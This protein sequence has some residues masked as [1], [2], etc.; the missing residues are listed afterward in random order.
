V[1]EVSSPLRRAWATA[2]EASIYV[3]ANST[4][5][6][7]SCNRARKRN[8]EACVGL[9]SHRYVRS[10]LHILGAWHTI[11]PLASSDLSVLA[12]T[13]NLKIR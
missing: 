2:N 13:R 6:V 4:S 3:S 5:E 8:S 12:D 9:G 10:S 1:T 11:S 7:S